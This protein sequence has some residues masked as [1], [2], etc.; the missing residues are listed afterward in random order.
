M[1][2]NLQL[3]IVR[4][5]ATPVIRSIVCAVLVWCPPAANA[6]PPQLSLNHLAGPIYI[7]ED[8]YYSKENSMVYVGER[9]VTVIGATWTPQTAELLAGEIRKITDKPIG[10]VVNTN[11]HTDRAGG[12]AYWRGSGAQI[13]STR[14][15]YDLLNS[16][17]ARIVAWTRNA[18]ADYPQPPLVL[19]TKIYAGDFE[20]QGGRIKAIY[21][22]PSHTPDG[23]FVYFP[24]EKVLYG[25]CILK[26]QLG[27]LDFADLAAYPETLRKLQRLKLDIDTIVAGHGSAVHGPELIEQYLQLLKHRAADIETRPQVSASR[28]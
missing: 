25:G 23:I 3:F 10:E 27:N 14:M 18:F 21:L 2:K 26:E 24:N 17:W 7:A 13:V 1:K 16:D 22:G 5:C 12:N 15:T 28:L 4:R 6:A 19:P 11:Y 20:L 9:S 8:S